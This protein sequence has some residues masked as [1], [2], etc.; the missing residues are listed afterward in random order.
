M[1]LLPVNLF[2]GEILGFENL[3]ALGEQI[4]GARNPLDRFFN[5][6][7][8]EFLKCEGKYQLKMKLPFIEKQD[9]VL[10]KIADELIVRVG[11]FKRTVMLP[12]QVAALDSLKATLEGQY[13]WI[14]FDT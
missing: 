9:V 14:H 2:R 8:Y 10:H 1:P 3:K 4:Y 13:L 11:G 7:P 12:R 6:K 5:G